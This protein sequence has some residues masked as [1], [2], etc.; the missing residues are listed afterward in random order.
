MLR[1][2]ILLLALSF[3]VVL[4]SPF[5]GSRA[6]ACTCGPA[7]YAPACQ[8]ISDTPVA[9]LG[10][11]V[12]FV[13]DPKGRG[14]F[15]RYN[16]RFRVNRVYKGL[17]PATEEVIVNPEN[18]TSCA[19]EYLTGRTY[20]MFALVSSQKPLLLV[21]GGCSGSRLADHN[22]ADL[23]YLD[24]Y[25]KGKTETAVYGRVLQWVTWIGLPRE[26]ESS[27]VAGAE[28]VLTNSDHRFTYTS[29]PD[30]SF[31]F[32]GIPEGE[33]QLSARHDQ[34]AADPPTHKVAVTGGGCNQVFVQ[35]KAPSSIEG[36][37]LTPGGEPASQ[38]RVELL[39]RNQKGGWYHTYKMWTQ[40]NYQ[41]KFT[42]NDIE[43]GDY[44]LGYEIWG[45]AP[46]NHTPYP[47]HYFPGVADRSGAGIISLSP[48][49]SLKDLELTLPPAHTPRKFRI[50]VVWPDGTP[51]GKNLLQ[52]FNQRGLIENLEGK[53]HDGSL[54]FMGYQER[55]YEFSAR[56]W[57]DNL[58]GGTPVFSKRIA[59][60]DPVK[61]PPGKDAVEIVLVLRHT[62]QRD[63]E[64]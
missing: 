14:S 20:I 57:V 63:D 5:F 30:G 3:C 61:V 55:A 45:D 21:A 39:K 47:T 33:Y 22:K 53:N 59:K 17:D 11:C 54:T 4:I 7:T 36:V 25:A 8:L 18:Y 60:P 44:I 19:T 37:L 16:Y 32:K 13:P 24:S 42:F 46:S 34:Y 56:Y 40:T 2:A 58:G 41:G 31:K 28:V 49:Q 9:F 10:E 38:M 29:E 15:G 23:D 1:Q 43:S 64:R 35:L 27:P 12:A 50:K 62:V 52:I 51:P 48:R 26:D 6:S